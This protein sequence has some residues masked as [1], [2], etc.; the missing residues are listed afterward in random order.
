[1]TDTK[2]GKCSI[3][4][5]LWR[6]L[7]RCSTSAAASKSTLH[8]LYCRIVRLGYRVKDLPFAVS[9]LHLASQGCYYVSSVVS[10]VLVRTTI[11]PATCI[12][13]AI[14]EA[15]DENKSENRVLRLYSLISTTIALFSL[16]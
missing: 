3:E 16:L 15:T 12:T 9:L 8:H 11:S 5:Q 14:R 7:Y 4:E 10:L 6:Y 2:S 13:L 1:M